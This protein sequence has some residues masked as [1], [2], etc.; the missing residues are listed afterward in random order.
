MAGVQPM[1]DTPPEIAEAI[2]K[3]K[4]L[5]RS[6]PKACLRKCPSSGEVQVQSKE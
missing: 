6:L 1:T 5:N 3:G 4:G 2:I